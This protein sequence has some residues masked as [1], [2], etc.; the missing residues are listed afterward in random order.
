VF[1]EELDQ[2]DVYQHIKHEEEQLECMT[3]EER[4]LRALEGRNYGIKMEV[5]EYVGSLNQRS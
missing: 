3:F 1:D 2:G 4:M 5:L